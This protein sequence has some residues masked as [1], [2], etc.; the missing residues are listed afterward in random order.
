MEP[1]WRNVKGKLQQHI[2][3]RIA[4]EATNNYSHL[5]FLTA[6]RHKRSTIA[7]EQ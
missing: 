5:A 7:A 3:T 1:V 4:K 2:Q 6:K